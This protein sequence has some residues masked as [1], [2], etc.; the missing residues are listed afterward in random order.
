MLEI[1]SDEYFMTEALKLAKRAMEE[2]EVPI[3]AILVCNNQIIARSYN[4]TEKL[5][6]TTAHAEILGI[7]SASEYLGSKFLNHCS[8]YV[9]LEPCMMCAGAIKWSR[10]HRLIIGALDEKEG[11]LTQYQA[12]RL[13]HPKTELVHGILANDSARLLKEF[14][15]QKR[16][17]PKR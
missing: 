2:D 8:M 3:G 15:L 6:D 9:T 17:R 13:L 14:F 7:T 10:V 5:T 4:Q 12:A 1:F 16:D 11:F